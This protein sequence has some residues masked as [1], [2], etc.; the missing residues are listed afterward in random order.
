[1]ME[2][3][4]SMQKQLDHYYSWILNDKRQSVMTRCWCVTVWTAMVVLITL[5]Q[6]NL[7]PWRFIIIINLPVFLFWMLDGFQNSFTNLNEQHAM[8]IEQALVSDKLEGFELGEHL[9][10]S[11]HNH[12]PFFFKVRAFLASIFLQETLFL[13]YLMLFLASVVLVML[14]PTTPV[15]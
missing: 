7:S 4:E 8:S 2:K 14:L 10:I 12:T 11:S 15:Q 6:L 5:S 13:F 3:R 9:L 1:M